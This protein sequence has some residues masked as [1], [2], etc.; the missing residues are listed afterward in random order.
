MGSLI[1]LNRHLWLT[2]TDMKDAEK[3][4]LLN[5][6]VNSSSLFGSSVESFSER[7]TEAQ[8][9]SRAISTFCPSAPELL[10]PCARAHPQPS[11]HHLD[12]GH[13]QLLSHGRSRSFQADTR[14]PELFVSPSLNGKVLAL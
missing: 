13:R 10:L 7:F 3:S 5:S 14:S 6:P 4:A 8:K 11:A 2:L 9:Q 12:C 1:V